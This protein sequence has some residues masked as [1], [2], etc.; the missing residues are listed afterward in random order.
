M[1]ISRKIKKF[2]FQY[3]LINKK[4]KY[5]GITLGLCYWISGKSI[6]CIWKIPILKRRILR[7]Y[8]QL[9]GYNTI[10]LKNIEETN[11]FTHIFDI[12]ENNNYYQDINERRDVID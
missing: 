4:G 3:F 2:H 9:E 7:F 6:V 8:K 12:G 11:C 1:H 5:V 10:Q